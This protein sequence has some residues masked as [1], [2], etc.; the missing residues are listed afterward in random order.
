MKLQLSTTDFDFMSLNN[1]IKLG[2]KINFKT[3]S[4]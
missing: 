3:Y 2:L 4:K 1:R